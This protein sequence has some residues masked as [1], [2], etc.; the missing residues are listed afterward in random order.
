M[1]A[2]C[3]ISE[4]EAAKNKTGYHR[5]LLKGSNE[6]VA[7]LQKNLNFYSTFKNDVSRSEYLDLIKN[8]KTGQKTNYDQ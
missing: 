7:I 8:E 4:L 1:R 2:N 3:K 5:L 6:H